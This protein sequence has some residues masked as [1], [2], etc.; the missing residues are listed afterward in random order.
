MRTLNLNTCAL[1]GA[2]ILATGLLAAPARASTFLPTFNP[3]NFTPG[4]AV[5]N[6]F[7]PLTPN[8]LTVLRGSFVENG[9][10]TTEELQ[11]RV[12]PGRTNIGGVD[13]TVVQDTAYVNS[14]LR[15]I[16]VDY[17]AQDTAGNVWYFGEDVT[18]YRRD[19]NGQLI[20]TDSKGSWRT[21]VHGGLPGY[22]MPASITLGLEYFQEHAP[23]DGALDVGLT[24]AQ[25][26]TVNTPYGTLNGVQVVYETSQ[27]DLAL[28]EL[29]YYA[30]G[31]G[32]VKVGEQ[33]DSSFN[34]GFTLDLVS[35]RTG[36]PEPNA[37]AL[38][39]SGF[40]LTG[41]V[42]RARRRLLVV[43]P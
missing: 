33:L 23:T 7:L 26:Q 39:I 9:E 38:M 24:F 41:A 22:A 5:N 37:W 43:Y 10:T 27:I 12:M 19:A 13:V 21:G 30:P 18:N 29:K 14:V 28:K 31:L 34:P 17:F 36:V 25:N 20:G 4:A 15:E 16:A 8:T 11:R 3:A 1:L 32:L 40:A 2:T 42:I 35:V 6:T